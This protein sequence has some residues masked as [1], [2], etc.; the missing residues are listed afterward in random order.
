MS[1]PESEGS[2]LA[3]FL[4]PLGSSVFFLSMPSA[5]WTRPTHMPESH[6]LYSEAADLNVNSYEKYLN[7]NIQMCIGPNIW[8]LWSSQVD[9]RTNYHS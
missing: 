3:K 5:V 1:Q 7:I 9:T 8:V 4:L 2:L 6:L